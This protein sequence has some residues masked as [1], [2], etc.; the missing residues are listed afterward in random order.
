MAH[1]SLHATLFNLFI[2][3]FFILDLH[4]DSQNCS[5]IPAL[6][7]ILLDFQPININDFSSAQGFPSTDKVVDSLPLW[8]FCP[9]LPSEGPVN[10]K[11]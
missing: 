2:T 9:S 7:L 10:S 8:L 5:P 1:S 3:E 6:S 4:L 11:T